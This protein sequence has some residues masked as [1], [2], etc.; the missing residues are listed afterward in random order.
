[1]T[2]QL[3]GFLVCKNSI[4]LATVQQHLP[5]HIALTR[6]EAGCIAFAVTPTADPMVWQVAE[7]F[8]DS[9]AFHAHQQRVRGSDWGRATAGIERRYTITGLEDE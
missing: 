8:A 1:M 6:A 7:T 3:N 4:E 9:A 5:Q 2:V